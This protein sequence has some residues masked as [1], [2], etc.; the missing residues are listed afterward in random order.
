MMLINEVRTPMLRLLLNAARDKA[1]IE[2]AAPMLVQ[3]Q[4]GEA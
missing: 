1:P 3:M 4:D 2:Q